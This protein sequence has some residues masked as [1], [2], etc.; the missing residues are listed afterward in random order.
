MT[1]KHLISFPKCLALSLALLAVLPAAKATPVNILINN[2]TGLQNDQVFVYWQGGGLDATYNSGSDTFTISAG[3]A[4]STNL[5]SLQDILSG[6]MTLNQVASGRLYFTFGTNFSSFQQP[7]LS[8]TNGYNFNVANQSIEL[9]YNGTVGG[10]DI[11]YIDNFTAPIKV[12]TY[13]GGTNGT[14]LSTNGIISD[15]TQIV[16]QLATL[17][18]GGKNAPNFVYGTNG[19]LLRVLGVSQ[20]QQPGN[21]GDGS[22]NSYYQPMTSYLNYLQSNN[23][24]TLINNPR[25]YQNMTTNFVTNGEIV[26]TNITTNNWKITPVFSATVSNNGTVITLTNGTFTTSYWT[27]NASQAIAGPTFSNCT[28]QVVATNANVLNTILLQAPNQVAYPTNSTLTYN[29]GYQSFL[30]WTETNP[31]LVGGGASN[32]MSQVPVD[33]YYA[34]ICLGLAGSTVTN[35]ASGDT[36]AIDTYD[37]THYWNWSKPI[38]FSDV[39]TNTNNYLSY[40]NIIYQDSTNSSYG[41]AY[42]DRFNSNQVLFTLGSNGVGASNID[43]LVI[44]L[45][46]PTSAV[47]EPGTLIYGFLSMIALLIA[48]RLR[49]ISQG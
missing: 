5:V 17:N 38:S 21:V 16:N 27:T 19:Q 34:A 20:T 25:Q 24:Q 40:G 13:T 42:S 33:D 7:N 39:Q 49:R 41:Y 3:N 26:S 32:D 4:L 2:N 46:A 23:V 14:S 1:T 45:D 29:T 30:T 36:N 12:V 48:G 8:N 18:P 31:T 43:T 15:A 22:G 6:G 37:T 44:T 35:T 9:N 10:G 11:T 47:P 28:V